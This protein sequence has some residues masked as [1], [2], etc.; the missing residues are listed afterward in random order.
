MK[1]IL[2]DDE[3]LAIKGLKLLLNQ[4]GDFFDVVAVASNGLKA[5]E[6]IELYQPDLIFLDI[7]MPVYNGFE[8]LKKLTKKPL[9]V[10]TTAYNAFAVRAFE[11]NSFDYLL[12]PIE[13]QRF[14]VTVERLQ[15]LPRDT[16][17]FNFDIQ[18]LIEFI[19][20]FP[21]KKEIHSL[22][23]KIGDRIIFVPILEITH[24]FAEERYVILNTID[25]KQHLINLTIQT[26]E[27]RLPRQFVRI[28]RASIINFNHILEAQKFF[29]GK[30]ILY[31]KDPKKSKIE[32]GS[33]YVGNL[34]KLLEI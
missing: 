5:V 1:T 24:F 18:K 11:E 32:T 21:S 28:S 8:V 26:L 33:K 6:L 31:M 4:Y 23:V 9:I 34:T 10:F 15:K 3:E 19:E 17:M 29:G 20:A 25:G 16:Q 27:E 22:T 7:E 13:K 2:I 30:Y 12:K 14:D